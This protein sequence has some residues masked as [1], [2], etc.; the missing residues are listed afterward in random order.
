M[1][2][3]SRR[4]PFVQGYFHGGGFVPIGYDYV[5]G[6]LVVNEYEAMQVKEVYRL[7]IDKGWSISKIWMHMNDNY[8]TKYSSWNHASA[9]YS[10]FTPLYTGKVQYC[11][12]SYEGKHEAIIDEETYNRAIAR[13]ND[14]RR[15]ET[16]RGGDKPFQVS[17]LLG[18][19]LIRCAHCNNTFF[20]RGVTS[21]HAPNQIYR[22]YYT[23]YSRAKSNRRK[24]TG[25]CN[26]KMYAVSELDYIIVSEIRKLSFDNSYLKNKMK[27]S[28]NSED[29]SILQRQLETLETQKQRIL[30]LYQLGTL[31][32][33]DLN[34]RIEM[35]NND[36]LKITAQME[37]L[38]SLSAE[39]TEEDVADLLQSCSDIFENGTIEEK[40]RIVTS[41]IKYIEIDNDDIN[42]HWA[43]C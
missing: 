31:R 41:L 3:H 30:D 29:L 32:I 43:F 4:P 13:L 16:G 9:V 1:V 22:P 35:I 37:S 20:S 26:N 7:F 36:C 8:T 15:K 34:E 28:D 10:C 21:G 39:L 23:C 38:Q 18:G 5:N 6:N 11:G 24:I 40:R 27:A 12:I 17:R 33:E 14:P 42:I 2:G 25:I 19:G